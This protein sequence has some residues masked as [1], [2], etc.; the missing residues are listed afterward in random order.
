MAGD[1]QADRQSLGPR[2]E[3][4]VKL[5]RTYP[6]RLCWGGLLGK[7]RGCAVRRRAVNRQRDF[8]ELRAGGEPFLV[9]EWL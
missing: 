6:A 7:E 5:R 2:L 1:H 8:D 4:M 3:G 9:R